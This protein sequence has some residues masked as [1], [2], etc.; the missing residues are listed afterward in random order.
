LFL[1]FGC[2]LTASR[3]AFVALAA[4]I[5]LLVFFGT[6]LQQSSRL[7]DLAA[8]GCVLLTVM[9][10]AAGTSS[11]RPWNT[12]QSRFS[13]P[14]AVLT[15]S[16]RLG[17][18]KNAL[19]T[20]HSSTRYFVAGTGTGV[21]PEVLARQHGY[22]MPDGVSFR[23]LDCH[24]AFVE[25]LV[26]YGLL[27]AAAGLCVIFRAQ[28]QAQRLDRRDGTVNRRAILLCFGLLSMNLVTFYDPMF[29]AAGALILAMLSEPAGFSPAVPVVPR[30]A[31]PVPRARRPNGGTLW[32]SRAPGVSL[33]C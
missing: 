4:A 1:S 31:L 8:L 32:P 18:W 28:R 17:L 24:N 19:R 22:L 6:R 27:G 20:W 12:L 3:G 23:P 5:W 33:R 7:K 29:I 9:T 14:T 2:V 25:W 15:A 11:F 16:G 30:A 26:S 13:T 10:F 21:A